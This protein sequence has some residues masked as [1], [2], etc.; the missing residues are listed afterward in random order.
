MINFSRINQFISLFVQLSLFK[1]IVPLI[2]FVTYAYSYFLLPYHFD[3]DQVYYIKA[4][5]EV[6]DLK[7]ADALDV[8][9]Q[10]IFTR[11]PIHFFIIWVTSSLGFDKNTVMSFSNAI[12]ASLF[13]LVLRRKGA[14]IFWVLWITFSGYYLQ[15]MFFTL[16]RTKFAFI[17]LLMYLLTNRRWLLVVAVFTHVLMLIPLSLNL[18]AEKLYVDSVAP[19]KSQ[20]NSLIKICTLLVI[21]FLGVVIINSLGTHIYDKYMFYY[22]FYEGTR[23]L[24]GLGSLLLCCLTILTCQNKRKVLIFYLGLMVLSMLLGSSRLNMLG[25]FG[26]L[27][28]SNFKHQAFY[29]GA[30][31]LGCYFLNKSWT[32]ATNIYYF[33]G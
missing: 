1:L 22:H 27:Y 19:K 31:L 32:Y 11:E 2:F 9:R 30:L 23:V 18:I 14:S 24:E 26:F 10:I 4:Y 25:F 16:E 21:L 17:F 28:F 33:G 15:T 29:V 5:E 8:Y 12:L 3:G 13:A 7:F 6:A 20:S